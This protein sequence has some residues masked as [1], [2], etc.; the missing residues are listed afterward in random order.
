MI[1]RNFNWN[2]GTFSY[3]IKKSI[4][5]KLM[6]IISTSFVKK[7]NIIKFEAIDYVYTCAFDKI[8]MFDFMPHL[9]YSPINYNTDIQGDHLTNLIQF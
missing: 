8:N 7:K 6:E 1:Y 3:V 5:K 2:R 4:C 9:Y